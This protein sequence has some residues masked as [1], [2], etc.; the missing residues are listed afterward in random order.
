MIRFGGVLHDWPESYFREQQTRGEGLAGVFKQVMAQH[1]A[2]KMSQ[3]RSIL[4][5]MFPGSAFA[6]LQEKQVL[7]CTHSAPPP[8]H[9]TPTP[10]TPLAAVKVMRKKLSLGIEQ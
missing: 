1:K 3:S 9:P 6:K 7:S 10:P 4:A 5:R 2:G 8:P